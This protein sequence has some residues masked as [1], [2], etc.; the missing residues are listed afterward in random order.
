M[1]RLITI[2]VLA[3]VLAVILAS[4][5]PTANQ[6]P[7]PK[8]T[9]GMAKSNAVQLA[10]QSVSG[11]DGYNVYRGST[12]TTVTTLVSPTGGITATSFTDTTAG[13]GTNYFYAVR[14]VEN[15]TESPNSPIVQATPVPQAC[16]TGNAIVLE[17]CYPGNNPWNV[18]NPATIAA[19]GIEGFA[20]AQSINKGG[21]VGLKVN[22]AN[23]TTF[24]V[25]IYRTGYYGGAGA[26][27]F[28]VIR[29]LAGSAQGACSTNSTTTGLIDC[30]N[31]TTSLTLTT[32]QSWP[33]G[34]YAIRLVREDTGADNQ[35]LLVVRD[36]SR[37]AQIVY[38]VGFST[39]QAYNNYGGKSLYDFNSQGNTTVAGSPRAVKVSYDRPFEQPRSGLRDWYTRTESATVYWLEQQGYDVGYVANTDIGNTPSLIQG[40]EAY[41]SP[42][43]DEYVSTEMRN[44]MKTARDSGTGLFFSG[45]NEVYWKIRFEN[46]PNG[47][48]ANR[49]QVSYKSTQSGGPDPT[50]IP[51]GTWRDPAGANAPEN[52]LTGIMY[53]G[54]NDNTYFPLVVSALEGSDRVYRYTPLASQAAGT[55]MSLGNSLIGWEWDA[56]VANGQEPPGVKT[57]ATSPV[58]GELVQNN[59]AN[60][61]PSGSIG[62]NMVKYTAA[63][64]ALVFSTG[65]NNWNR[66]LAPNAAGVGEP[67]SEIQ[68]ITTNVLAD[69]GATPQTP[70]TGIVLDAGADPNRPAAPTNVVPTTNGPDSVTINWSPVPGVDGYNVYRGLAARS[71][72]QPLG[73]LANPTLITGTSFTDIGLSP[74][75]AYFYVVVAVNAGV[76]SLPSAESTA[77]TAA[78]AG[79]PTRIDVGAS[80]SYTSSTG[81]QWSADTFFSGGNLRSV[82]TPIANTNDPKLYQ[83]ERFG[84]FNY[85]IPV[86][87]GS[88]NVRFHFGETYFG[89]TPALSPCLGKRIF[90][91]DIVDTPGSTPDLNNFDICAAA[92]GPAIATVVTVPN[93]NVSDGILFIKSSRGTIDDPTLSAIEV[94]PI[95]LAPPTVSLTAPGNAETDVAVGD[96]ARATFSRGMDAST[97]TNS[98]FTLSGPSGPVAASVSFDSASRTATLAPSAPLDY[99]T[100][101]T[102]TIDSTVKASDGAPLGT[103]YTWN[104]TTQAAPPPDISSTSP[105]DGDIG[106][107]PTT[108][109]SATFTRPMDPKTITT[110][111]FTLRDSSGALVPADVSYNSTLQRATLAPTSPL[112]VS[113]TYTAR[114]STTVSTALSVGLPA[115][116]V[117]SFTVAD[118]PPAPPTVTSFVPAAAAVDVT[119][120]STVTATF[121]RPMD[122]A[123]LSSSTFTLTNAGG[124]VPATVTYDGA[125]ATATLTPTNMLAPSTPYTA[126]LT[127][128]VR[129]EDGTAF[130]GK[131]WGFTTIAAPTIISYT[132]IDGATFVDRSQSI[133]VTFSRSMAASS[134]TT[135]T[136]Q[137]FAPDGSVVPAAVSYDD[138][139]HT[140]TLT[141]SALLVGGASYAANVSSSIRAI[142]GSPLGGADLV[143]RFIT[144][145]CP[146]SLFPPVLA[147]AIQ[148]IP[149]RDGRVGTGPWTYELGV[150]FKVDEAMRLNGIRFYKSKSETGVHVANLWT[151]SGLLLASTTATNETASGWQEATFTAPAPL[152]QAGAVYIASVNA[153]SFYNSTVGGMASQ[154]ISG[155]LRSVIGTP[156]GVYG[157]AAGMFPT[158]TYNSSNY[159]TDVDVVPD[160]DPGAP[161]VVSTAP[162]PNANAVDANLPLTASFS[163]PMDPSTI[164]ASNFNVLPV[165]TS[166]GTD[167]GGAVDATI[168][169]DDS[170]NTAT[171]NP[172][173]PLTHGVVYRAT[174]TTAIRAQDG[175]PL[176]APITWTFTV[177]AP[178]PPLAVA[179]SPANGS[180]G[181]GVDTAVKLVFNRSVNS[182]TLTSG[183]AQIVAP[184]GSIVAGTI[185]YD[186]FAFTATITPSAKL[187]P[188]TTYTIRVNSGVQAPDG[189][190]L[191]NP[192]S[193]TFTTGTCPCTL[194]TGLLPKAV[195]NPVQDGRTG[196]GPWSYEL[197]TKITV[198]AP[199]SLTAIRFWKDAK[200]T[201]THTVRLWSSTG[202]LLA[203]LPVTGETAGAGWQQAN[204]ATPI[205]LAANTVYIV[206]VN[207]NA[208]FATTRSG[209]ATPLT[210]GIAHSANDVKNGV[211]GSAAGVFPTSSF[212]STNYFVDVVIR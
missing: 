175:K 150:K 153:N 95:A 60:Y 195:S 53:V 154:I 46:G 142:G 145:T 178:P 4:A 30:S 119:A 50:G 48:A 22:S 188:T 80:S 152:L 110:S 12:M 167:A 174:L 97:I 102:A 33:T 43:H 198:D 29:G 25:E 84:I 136:F 69:M 31:W 28:S 116:Y 210:S 197:G 160:G 209:L 180:T 75:T 107:S 14:A 129:A 93:V 186:A 13:N 184:D 135:A 42:A 143:F 9:T 18:R 147:P 63:S 132:P 92:G 108:A 202:T 100:T 52:G 71:D 193:S 3:A 16:S 88:Y 140:A 196:A 87:N 45:G 56:R 57:L 51:T 72:G 74:T 17:N 62:V 20:T 105:N 61:N 134:I 39:F 139:T 207:A 126:T 149:T 192:F 157:A 111:S 77:T 163:R 155:P 148:N 165:G 176:A 168:S 81:Q 64:G 127:T 194:M 26:R 40:V 104:F 133:T 211:Y 103:D 47:G 38:G 7:A 37:K 189:T 11:V 54:D 128:A 36:D 89:S 86:A 146:C 156:N 98:T 6:P 170:T 181:I 94:I 8:G 67:E 85:S 73:A 124:T 169:Y 161:T 49:V 162:A 183:S 204:L 137:L 166:A 121:S 113:S 55:S 91:I 70:S 190:S 59:G 114:I 118:A 171:L 203:S 79:Q 32:T 205:A 65:T 82:S 19:G 200:E 144:S 112:A 27:L 34:T 151:S 109:V 35:I 172:S 23:G 44:A 158:S 21:S 159:F 24:R 90:N 10:W 41:I 2:G 76:Q 212:S 191:L 185:G 15:G 177:A 199:A 96:T 179:A 201:G 138:P 78:G 101:Y 206:S 117:W 68:Q 173:S 106:V 130:A 58:T 5:A 164:T 141:P 120:N 1:K 131:S 83:T 208:F 99:S 123:T 115:P 122:P 66:G 125:T 187:A 182:S